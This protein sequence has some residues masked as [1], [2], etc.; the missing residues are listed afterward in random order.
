[1]KGKSDL[2]VPTPKGR[3]HYETIKWN[4]YCK[5]CN[6]VL[7]SC[8]I[9][10]KKNDKFTV[11]F[12]GRFLPEAGVKHIL[13]AAKILEKKGVNFEKM[14]DSHFMLCYAYLIS[15]GFKA[16]RDRPTQTKAISLLAPS[17]PACN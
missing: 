14:L 13:E 10:D 12:R 2:R 3:D 17:N 8:H 6:K 1:M 5:G 16:E 15:E 7:C 4:Q 11:L 9:K